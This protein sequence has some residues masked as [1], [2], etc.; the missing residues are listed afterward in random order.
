MCASPPVLSPELKLCLI[1]SAPFYLL[2]Y[3][4]SPGV[5]CGKWAPASQLPWG[6]TAGGKPCTGLARE[7]QTA[8]WINSR[9]FIGSLGCSSA[10]LWAAGQKLQDC[11]SPLPQRA[12]GNSEDSWPGHVLFPR[13]GLSVPW[14]RLL[15]QHSSL[16]TEGDTKWNLKCPLHILKNYQT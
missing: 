11:H 10:L 4:A 3:S 13:R 7:L 15:F 6:K 1:R 8:A 16:E 5:R 2:K 12:K 9:L 14:Q